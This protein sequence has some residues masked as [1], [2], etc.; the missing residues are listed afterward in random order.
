MKKILTIAMGVAALTANAQE[1]YEGAAIATQDLNGTAKYVGMGG[2][3]EALG[4]DISTINTNPAGIGMFR[5]SWIG[6][7]A[8][9]TSQNGSY[10]GF[11]DF[12]VNN[13]KSGKTNADFNQL[14]FVY[15]TKAGKD[16]R[17]NLAF[18]YQK[19]RNFNQ[20]LQAVNT[21]NGSSANMV[22]Y[23]KE[24]NF[25]QSNTLQDGI[26]YEVIN[27]K[28]NYDQ[29]GEVYARGAQAYAGKYDNE[30]YISNFDFNISGNIHDRIYLGL[31]IGV[32]DV[33]YKG[34]NT[35]DEQLEYSGNPDGDIFGFTDIRHITGT[36]VDIK[37][38]AIFRPIEDS[39]FRF[40]LYINTPTWYELRCR[41]NMS[42]AAGFD[43]NYTTTDGENNTVDHNIS[44]RYDKNTSGYV[45]DYKY[46]I[47][48]PWRFGVSAGHTFG[49]MAA[50]GV[51]YEYAD[52][53]AIKNRIVEG[54]YW[55]Y[56]GYGHTETSKD[57]QMDEN[58]DIALKG[59][60]LLK[61][62]AEIKPVPQLAIRLGYNWQGAIYSDAGYKSFAID[63]DLSYGSVGAYYS[64][65][66]FV[67]WKATHRFTC[68][69]GVSLGK[70]WGLDLA[71]QYSTQK[72]DYYPFTSV[73]IP[74]SSTNGTL[75]ENIGYGTTVHNN[76]HQF[77]ATL[78]YRF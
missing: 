65:Y 2:A 66:D 32:K 19:S 26:I 35:Y 63:S 38:G 41:T 58:N 50:I 48:T 8:G 61:I 37:L 64:T 17:L 52:Y 60:S 75:D 31:T 78:G 40:G 56:D 51:T 25:R 36:G 53:S 6:L 69:L 22:N 20:I 76:R 1:T 7:S 33:R 21:L 67:N 9:F 30:G 27:D 23:I 71:Y 55:D 16:S 77:N 62:G 49:K 70:N 42:A 4:A 44:Y 74:T 34:I 5:S 68:G 24:Y 29:D 15:S 14:G 43:V 18:N 72:G 13:T 47:N 59:V 11:K 12:S 45:G 54:T 10:D 28:L 3:M 57:Y 39:P 73:S 46:C